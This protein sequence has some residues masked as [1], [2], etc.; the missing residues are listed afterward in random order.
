MTDQP[1]DP[2]QQSPSVQQIDWEAR[3]KGSVT[4]INELQGVIKNLNDQLA[5]LTSEKEQISSQLNLKQVE[6]DA[7]ITSTQKQLQEIVSAKAALETENKTLRELQAK[8]KLAK[9]MKRPDLLPIIDSIPYVEDANAMKEILS[10]FTG[11]ADSLVQQREQQLTVGVPL[12]A[13][14]VQNA[15]PVLPTNDRDWEK[16]INSMVLGSPERTKAMDAF[17][18]WGMNQGK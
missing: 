4:K 6:K 15:Q 7:S 2:V 11:W 10:T 5:G 3:Y 17:W 16:Y 14:A 9:D 18:Q 13:N 12:G 8:V 1:A